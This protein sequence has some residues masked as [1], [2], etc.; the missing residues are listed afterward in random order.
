MDNCTSIALSLKLTCYKNLPKVFLNR[1]QQKGDNPQ[2]P[3]LDI[4]V[5]GCIDIWAGCFLHD[6]T[7]SVEEFEFTGDYDFYDENSGII[8]G[9]NPHTRSEYKL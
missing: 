6:P 7:G 8:G 9:C 2:H 5:E 4:D 1:E 3:P